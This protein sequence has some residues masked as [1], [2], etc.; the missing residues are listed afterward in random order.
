MLVL[1][2]ILLGPERL[3]SAARTLG[4]WVAELRKLTGSFQ[5]ELDGVVGDVMRP[6]PQA[7]TSPAEAFTASSSDQRT[8]ERAVGSAAV[9]SSETS[10]VLAV[11]VPL[12]GTET[13]ETAG[14]PAAAADPSLN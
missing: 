9:A 6:V 1:A 14:P 3:P 10:G 11:D 2:L 4:K 5:A 13:A 8:V 7:T 12:P